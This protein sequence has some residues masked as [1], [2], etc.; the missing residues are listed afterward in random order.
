M[1]LSP[2]F[3]PQQFIPNNSVSEI[4]V[5]GDRGIGV[6]PCGGHRRKPQGISIP[7]TLYNTTVSL[8]AVIWNAK[9]QEKANPNSRARKYIPCQQQILFIKQIRTLKSFHSTFDLLHEQTCLKQG[10]GWASEG[11]EC[12]RTG[13]ATPGSS[14]SHVPMFK[15][16][17]V[18]MFK[19]SNVP[20]F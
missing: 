16:S 1:N 5:C 9:L 15:C 4:N 7:Q 2:T 3:Y 18:R 14:C 8:C 10:P 20:M 6:T 19:C 13:R 17:N 11:R 12:C